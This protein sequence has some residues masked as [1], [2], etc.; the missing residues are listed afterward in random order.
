MVDSQ[1]T[2]AVG[3]TSEDSPAVHS[4]AGNKEETHEYVTTM[5]WLSDAA[6]PISPMIVLSTD[7]EVVITHDVSVES[8]VM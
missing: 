5:C 3:A 2:V 7:R 6:P 1:V 4:D 8:G